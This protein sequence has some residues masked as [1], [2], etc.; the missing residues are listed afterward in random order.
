MINEVPNEFIDYIT[1]NSKIIDITIFVNSLDKISN[2]LQKNTYLKSVHIVFCNNNSENC[3]EE[4]IS[5]IFFYNYTLIMFKFTK[6][7]HDQIEI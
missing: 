6:F 1:F 2:I 5:N 3:T 4:N 7:I